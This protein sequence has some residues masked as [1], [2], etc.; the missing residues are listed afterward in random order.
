MAPLTRSLRLRSPELVLAMMGILVDHED[1]PD[2]EGPIPWNALASLFGDAFPWK[3]IE[4][5]I[6][7]LVAFGAI[8]RIGQAGTRNRADTRALRSTPLGR[9]WLEQT[10][11]PLPTL[12]GSTDDG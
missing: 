7:D 11:L 4:N 5:T 1:D 6:Y 2:T 12:K 9:A 8:H 10:V 3:T